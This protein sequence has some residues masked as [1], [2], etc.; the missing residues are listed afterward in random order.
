MK[1]YLTHLTWFTM[2]RRSGVLCVSTRSHLT[3]TLGA[4]LFVLIAFA[5]LTVLPLC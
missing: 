3:F 5:A 2:K 4:T 1:A